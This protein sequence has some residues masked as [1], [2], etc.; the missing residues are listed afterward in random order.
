MQEHAAEKCVNA[1]LQ[2]GTAHISLKAARYMLEKMRD[3]VEETDKEIGEISTILPIQ[4]DAA[5]ACANEIKGF[6]NPFR[7][8]GDDGKYK[9]CDKLPYYGEAFK[10]GRHIIPGDEDEKDFHDDRK[11]YGGVTNPTVH[12]AL[13]QIRQVVNELIDRYGHPHSIAIELGRDLPVGAKG[14]NAISVEQKANQAKMNHIMK[15]WWNSA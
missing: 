11:Y 14:R 5:I 6:N 8:K 2:D 1:L 10:D 4:P 15:N 7:N 13:N 12:I 9:I 3:G